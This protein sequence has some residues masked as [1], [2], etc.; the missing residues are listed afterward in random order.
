MR[1]AKKNIFSSGVPAI[2]LP[3]LSA[4][5]RPFGCLVQERTE[6]PDA[7]R[8]S[9]QATKARLICETVFLLTEMANFFYG[10]D[11]AFYGKQP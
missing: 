3:P 7:L 11:F 9:A 6:A 2:S 5:L 10:G 1:A 8:S 4:S